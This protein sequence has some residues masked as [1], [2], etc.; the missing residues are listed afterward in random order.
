MRRTFVLAAA[1]GAAL[2]SSAHAQLVVGNDQSGTA[3]IW[4]VDVTSG[5]ATSLY[6]NTTS[7]AKPWGMAY[8]PATNTL[9]WNNGGNLY[10]SPFSMSGLTPSAPTPMTFNAATVNFVALA[11]HNGQLLGT[12]NIA[13]EAVY[14]IDTATG[15]ATQLYVYPTAFDF[16]GLDSSGTTLYGLTDAAPSPSVR[17]L[18]SIDLAAQSTTF[19]APYPS[20]ETDIDGLAIGNGLAYYVTDGPNTTQASFYVFDPATG[21]Q[22]G[23]LPSP[24][25]GS[26]TFSAAAFVGGSTPPGCYANCDESTTTPVLNVA[27]FTCFLQRYAAGESYANCDNSTTTPVLNVADFTC[28]LQ[29]YAAGCP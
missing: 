11:W 17:G 5:A 26:G 1:A 27:D 24:F 8:D 21:N 18:Y 6:A 20:G 10:S 3:T 4:H 22:V 28:F 19:L 15:V 29:Q 13:T 23:T 16:G 2:A 25:T 7:D 12:R 14:S 9:W